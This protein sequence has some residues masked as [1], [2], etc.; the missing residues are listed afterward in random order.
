MIEFQLAMFRSGV[1]HIDIPQDMAF[2][3]SKQPGELSV[4]INENVEAIEQGLS[5]KL[6]ELVVSASQFVL[7]Y[8]AAF[9]FSWEMALS[10]IGFMPIFAIVAACMFTV[11]GGDLMIEW[12]KAYNEAG[13]IA[14]EAINSILSFIDKKP[15]LPGLKE[16]SQNPPSRSA[17]LRYGIKINHKCNFNDL[18][19][20]FKYLTD[21]EEL[22]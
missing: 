11:A 15:I 14:T 13:S 9:Y 3:D 8:V 6:V 22:K 10:L 18:R 21:V 16:I 2:F 4:M 17:K 1:P 7:S 5:K 19:E 12:R 20:K